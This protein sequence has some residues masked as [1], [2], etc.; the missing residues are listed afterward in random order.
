MPM[1]I[2]AENVGALYELQ[3]RSPVPV[4]MPKLANACLQEFLPEYGK[5]FPRKR[6]AA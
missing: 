3:D 4:S 2:T 6:A 1:I 5:R